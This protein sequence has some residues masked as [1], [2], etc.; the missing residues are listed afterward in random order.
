[1]KGLAPVSA[2]TDSRTIETGQP[3]FVFDVYRHLATDNNKE[4]WKTIAKSI[5]DKFEE[6]EGF[7]FTFHNQKKISNR[8]RSLS[9]YFADV[10]MFRF[11]CFQQRQR[12]QR[13]STTSY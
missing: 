6:A 10:T 3:F 8:A 12:N 9:S 7:L 13:L 4:N 2:D 5:V 11:Q 1:M